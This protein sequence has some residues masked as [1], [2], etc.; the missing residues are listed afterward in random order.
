MTLETLWFFIWALLWAVYFITDGFDL[1]VGALLPFLGKD[2]NAKRLMYNS[3]GPLW[4][5]NEVWL[6]TAGGV[7][8][9]AFPKAYAVMF[10][11]FYTAFF[12]LLIALIIRGISF[13]FR[14]KADSA[15]HK[16]LCDFCHFVGSVLI[17]IL[18]GVAFANIFRGLP[19]ENGVNK[20][21]FFSLLNPYGV[22]G[23]VFFLL[24]FLVHGTIW[25]AIRTHGDIHDSATR[26]AKLLWPVLLIVAV[27]FLVYTW[28]ETLLFKNYLAHPSLFVVPAIAVAAL[29]AIRFFV[30]RQHYWKAWFASAVT[31]M[32]TTFFAVIGLFP[33]ML[34]STIEPE[35]NS[36]LFSAAASSS[37]TLTVMLVVV[38]C[39][40]PF[41]IAYQL[42]AYRLFTSKLKTEE[43]IY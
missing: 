12:L 6:I 1:G 39:L 21:G 43:I 16:K 17:A 40:L 9:A 42:W 24:L 37:L 14:S 32:A 36:I 3:T 26:T 8:F 19:I 7:T 23:G 30:A 4:D 10:S 18:L 5:G 22:A 33:A 13:E 27:V 34:P 35:K 11:S 29:L 28:F 38:V 2:E 25:L 15:G 31:I 41:V 20:D